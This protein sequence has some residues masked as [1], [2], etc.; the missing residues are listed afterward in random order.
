MAQ[1][2][3]VVVQRVVQPLSEEEY[4]L[5]VDAVLEAK[6]RLARR[7]GHSPY[8]VAFGRDPKMPDSLLDDEDG[9][10]DTGMAY[11]LYPDVEGDGRGEDGGALYQSDKT[12]S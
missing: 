4:L 12:F 7:L 1:A 10:L 5:V 3:E 8:Q 2:S 11:E 9:S 6:N